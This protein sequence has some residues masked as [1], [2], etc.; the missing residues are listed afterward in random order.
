MPKQNWWGT[1]LME[2]GAGKAPAIEITAAGRRKPQRD[3]VKASLVWMLGV[4]RQGGGRAF[5]NSRGYSRVLLEPIDGWSPT[6]PDCR[7]Q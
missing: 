6:A 7:A 5:L 4:G 1:V 3:R 2:V